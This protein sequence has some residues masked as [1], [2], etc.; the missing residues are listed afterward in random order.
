MSVYET[1]IANWSEVVNGV[2]DFETAFNMI[3]DNVIAQTKV[4]GLDDLY[5]KSAYQRPVTQDDQTKVETEVESSRYHVNNNNVVAVT[6]GDI[7]D[8]V[9][10]AQKTFIL[11]Y[12]NYAICVTYNGFV[13]TVEAGGYVIVPTAQA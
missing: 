2:T 7:V 11:N 9:K 8:G 3:N 12:N 1:L 5:E 4:T 6:Y 10:Q 13:Y